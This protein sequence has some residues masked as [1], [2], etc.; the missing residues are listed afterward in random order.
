MREGCLNEQ[1]AGV[2]QWNRLTAVFPLI[3]RSP[4]GAKLF[5]SAHQSPDFPE[6]TC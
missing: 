5:Q 3:C 1:L 6:R 2:K 4:V